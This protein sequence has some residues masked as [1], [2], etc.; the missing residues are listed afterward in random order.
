M[1]FTRD[2]G[3]LACQMDEIYQDIECEQPWLVV[4][5]AH[6]AVLRVESGHQHNYPRPHPTRGPGQVLPLSRRDWGS[7]FQ[8]RDSFRR[9]WRHH[10]WGSAE[11]AAGPPCSLL[12]GVDPSPQAGSGVPRH[13]PG[14]VTKTIVFCWLF[15]IK[16]QC[17]KV[18]FQQTHNQGWRQ[19]WLTVSWNLRA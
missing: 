4:G 3:L 11:S 17:E 1:Y 15:T 12:R 6:L 5:A 14:R 8:E 19:L 10:E 7:P 13:R 16:D 9:G 2:A 18:P